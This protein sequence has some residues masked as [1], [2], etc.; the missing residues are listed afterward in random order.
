LQAN[1]KTDCSN[2]LAESQWLNIWLVMQGSRL[3]NNSDPMQS[4]F[5]CRLELQYLLNT[6]LQTFCCRK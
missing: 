2:F 1:H 5:T 3:P 6:I 4:L